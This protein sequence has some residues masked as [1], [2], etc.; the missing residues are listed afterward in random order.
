MKNI[1]ADKHLHSLSLHTPAQKL[2][3][4]MESMLAAPNFSLL[5]CETSQTSHSLVTHKYIQSC[6]M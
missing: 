1:S 2:E 5:Y 3:V 6:N 4:Q